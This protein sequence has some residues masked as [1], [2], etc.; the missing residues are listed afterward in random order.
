MSYCLRT[1]VVSLSFIS[2]QLTDI[3]ILQ[4]AIDKSKFLFG[5]VGHNWGQH[6]V[7]ELD[8][9]LNK[10]VDSVLDHCTCAR[11]IVHRCIYSGFVLFSV[12]WDPTREDD[13]FFNQSASCYALYYHIQILIHRPFIS[14]PNK[15]S[16]LS[17]PSLAEGLA[18]TEVLLLGILMLEPPTNVH[19]CLAMMTPEVYWEVG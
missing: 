2:R 13:N 1:I 6:I 15:P 4:Y 8:S 19:I 16:P 11:I 9:A 5:Y 18:N 12:Q 3:Y 17:F 10:W 7:A 14:T